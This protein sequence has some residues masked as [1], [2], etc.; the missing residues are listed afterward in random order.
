MPEIKFRAPTPSTRR[1]LL[2]PNSL[3]DF[4]TELDGHELRVD[5]VPE[6]GRDRVDL[7]AMA[8]MLDDEIRWIGRSVE[9]PL[10]WLLNFFM[11]E[12]PLL[13]PVLAVIVRLH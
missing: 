12:Y 5:A 4:H 11:N 1:C 13:L 6:P 7:A 9:V 10:W 3:L 2:E 8:I